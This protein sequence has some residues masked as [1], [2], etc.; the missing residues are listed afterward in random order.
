M[1]NLIAELERAT[2]GSREFD[3]RIEITRRSFLAGLGAAAVAVEIARIK[4]QIG[5]AK[6]AE[7]EEVP[8]FSTSLDA[9]LTLVPEGW[10]WTVGKQ[11]IGKYDGPAAFCWKPDPENEPILAKSSVPALALCIVFL[12]ARQAMEEAG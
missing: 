2:K 9:A 11:N 6:F 8:H 7:G 4:S 3:V 5:F 12:R 1:D 10:R